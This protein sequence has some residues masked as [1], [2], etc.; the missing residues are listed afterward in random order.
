M[1]DAS[2]RFPSAAELIMGTPEPKCGSARI[3]CLPAVEGGVGPLAEEVAGGRGGCSRWTEGRREFCHSW[4]VGIDR[5]RRSSMTR[6]ALGT[7]DDGA[8][9]PCIGNDVTASV[10]L[11]IGYPLALGVLARLRTVLAERRVWWFAALEAATASIAAGWMSAESQESCQ[12]MR[13]DSGVD[14][15]EVDANRLHHFSPCPT[16]VARHDANARTMVNGGADEF[17]EEQVRTVLDGNAHG[18]VNA[19]PRVKHDE[20]VRRG[21]EYAVQGGGSLLM[22]P[23]ES[24][25][26]SRV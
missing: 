3:T 23:G 4:R 20:A 14:G 12:W 22:P 8:H 16:L 25:R 7:R 24:P 18:F 15:C 17:G 6:R 26:P 1:T 10:L 2:G 5:C 11:V 13:K 19:R 21:L 9:E